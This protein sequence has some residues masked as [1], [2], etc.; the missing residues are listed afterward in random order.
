MLWQQGKLFSCKECKRLL[1]TSTSNINKRGLVNPVQLQRLILQI[2]RYLLSW[3][4]ERSHQKAQPT[5]KCVWGQDQ[6][7]GVWKYPQGWCLQ[8]SRKYNYPWELL[9][10]FWWPS[11][12]S[13]LWI[14][15]PLDH[16]QIS[17]MVWLSLYRVLSH[18]WFMHMLLNKGLEFLGQGKWASA[19]WEPARHDNTC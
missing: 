17:E 18:L 10:L 12:V 16:I 5:S 1:A 4:H 13:L 3:I 2:H 11:A 19:S 15:A 14:T 9:W 8:L 6:C 7:V